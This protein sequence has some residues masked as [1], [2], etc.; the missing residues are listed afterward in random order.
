MGLLDRAVGLKPNQA[1]ASLTNLS[2]ANADP[3]YVQ[4]NPTEYGVDQGAH[5]ADQNVPGLDMPLLQFV[6]G[7]SQTLTLELLL[8]AY[9][10]RSSTDPKVTVAGRLK[11]IRKFVQ[12]D[13]DLHAPPVCQFKWKDVEFIGVVTQ[14]RE[15]YTLFN[16]D[17][18][19]LRARITLTMK[20]YKAPEV[21]L[22][23][24]TRNSPDRTRVRALRERETLAQLAAEASGH[25]RLWRN[26]AAAND[27]DRP[28]FVP[29]GTPLKI[30][31]IT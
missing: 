30:P 5:Y 23:D 29:P 26:I 9:D 18:T 14:L 20:S 19:I 10:Q 28:R 6:R 7:D 27:I 22:R 16:D 13:G 25:P 4:F 1:N 15:K 17:G 31:A 2:V 12:I 8:D 11:E 21:Q 3:L 24:P